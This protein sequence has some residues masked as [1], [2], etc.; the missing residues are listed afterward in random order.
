MAF[1]IYKI[2]EKFYG[3]KRRYTLFKNHPVN[4]FSTP[5]GE[6]FTHNT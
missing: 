5:L 1:F 6:K 4:F 2:L 3:A